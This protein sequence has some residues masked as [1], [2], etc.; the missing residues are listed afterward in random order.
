MG[1]ERSRGAKTCEFI[2]SKIVQTTHVTM[3]RIV[4]ARSVVERC[5]L[6]V[7]QLHR[8]WWTIP[9]SGCQYHVLRLL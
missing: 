2:S 7:H 3:G 8:R 6:P 5:A 4:S 9:P 1:P